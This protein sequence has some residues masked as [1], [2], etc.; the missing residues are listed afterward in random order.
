MAIPA[1]GS[2]RFPAL[3]M[4]QCHG[5]Q[6]VEPSRLSRQALGKLGPM[7]HNCCGRFRS[8]ANLLRCIKPSNQWEKPPNSSGEF[9]GFPNHRQY[10]SLTS[11]INKNWSSECKSFRLFVAYSLCFLQVSLSSAMLFERLALWHWV[12]QPFIA[13]LHCGRHFEPAVLEASLIQMSLVVTATRLEILEYCKIKNRCV[14]IYIHRLGR[15]SVVE[16]KRHVWSFTLESHPKV[17]WS[18]SQNWMLFQ[19]SGSIL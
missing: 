5:C 9:T 14:Y 1:I 17:A 4:I 13:L 8:P 3:S 18:G 2:N 10:H 16:L 19:I 12:S 7:H 11:K 6:R 15:I